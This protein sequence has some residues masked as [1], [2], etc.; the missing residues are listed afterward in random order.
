MI[1]DFHNDILTAKGVTK[2]PT[3]YEH[4]KIVTAVY[5]S[6]LSFS[7][8]VEISRRGRIIAFEDVGYEDLDFDLLVKTNP[9]YVGIT[10][11]GENRFGYGCDYPYGLKKE[12]VELIAKLNGAKIAVDTAHLSKG[13]F[14]D[15]IDKADKV[16]NSHV[17][18]NGVF[19]HKR[20]LDDWQI[21]LL[22]ERNGLIGITACGYFMT[23]GKLCKIDDYIDNIIY[24]YEKYGADNVCM[25]TDFFGTD[26]LPQ[27]F[28]ED[29]S[30][31]DLLKSK[32]IA[33]G[34][35]HEDVEKF[36][37]GNLSNFLS[38]KNN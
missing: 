17:C 9:V 35:T 33:R 22:V 31:I 38:N 27:N 32:L 8:A 2:L 18:F 28:G 1:A 15:A 26:F 30:G 24:F 19:R 12:G 29:Y 3:F 21:K 13:G 16:I 37:Y 25:G 14:I 4:N 34:M 5:R 11:N 36:I 7:N 20:N 6:N 10:W 23:N